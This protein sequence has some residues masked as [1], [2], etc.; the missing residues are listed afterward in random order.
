[1][2]LCNKYVLSKTKIQMYEFLARVLII[3]SSL[4]EADAC[5]PV[6]RVSRRLTIT[7]QDFFYF[8]EHYGQQEHSAGKDNLDS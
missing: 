8:L 3:I 5:L 1:M 4:G 6:G 7:I 2:D